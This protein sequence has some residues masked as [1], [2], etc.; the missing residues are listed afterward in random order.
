MAFEDG[1]A[2]INLQMP[3]RIPRTEYSAPSPWDLIRAVTGIEV[4]V[5]SPDE[6]KD[7]AALEFMRAWNFDFFWNTLIGDTEFG[8]FR[9]DMGHAEYAAGGVDRRDTIFC[10]YTDPEQVLSFDPWETLGAKNKSELTRRFEQHYRAS[11]EQQPFGVNMTGVYVTLISGLIGLFGWDML[12]LAA[13]VDSVR[14]GQ[15]TNRYAAWVQQYFDA[16]AE[17]DV[18]VVMVHDDF[19]WSSGAIFR[20]AWYREYVFP[21]YKKYMAPLIESG[22][23]VMFLENCCYGNETMM[24]YRMV[25]EGVFGEPYYAEGSYAHSGS[26]STTATG[27]RAARR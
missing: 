20:P 13:G 15:M 11:L 7:R 24:I 1:W 16:L 2:A 5:G 4:G 6:I 8:Q 14:F 22:K 19:V 18:P 23:R 12:L 26:I 21:N 10:P 25:R 17:A 3:K 9:T 27:W